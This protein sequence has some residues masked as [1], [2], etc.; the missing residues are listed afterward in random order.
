[1]TSIPRDR[2]A[3]LYGPSQGDRVRRVRAIAVWVAAHVGMSL[4]GQLVHT[5]PHVS[6]LP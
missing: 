1:M 3:A 6:C 2:Y 4:N 5:E